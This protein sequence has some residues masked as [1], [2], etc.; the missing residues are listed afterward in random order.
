MQI[1]LK[2]RKIPNKCS[3]F[4]YMGFKKNRHFYIETPSKKA[5]SLQQKIPKKDN[6]LHNCKG[7]AFRVIHL[8]R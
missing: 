8:I 1:I 3:K 2:L 4:M 6:L 5:K 7:L